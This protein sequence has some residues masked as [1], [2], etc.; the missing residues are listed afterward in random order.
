MRSK[1]MMALGLAVMVMGALAGCAQQSSKLIMDN[2]QVY[3]TY[4][5]L[6]SQPQ[7]STFVKLL[8]DA[9]LRF[10][11]QTAGNYT[12]FAPTNAA[13]AAL[14]KGELKKLENERNRNELRQLLWYHIASVQITPAAAA[15]EPVQQ[16]SNQQK[17]FIKVKHGQIVSIDNAAVVVGPQYTEN[18]VIYGIDHVIMPASH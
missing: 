16:M 4:R 2:T 14:P 7:F 3:S 5:V 18:G 12:V 15:S 1:W 9:R 17:A 8:K 10:S 13:F 11:L 6:A